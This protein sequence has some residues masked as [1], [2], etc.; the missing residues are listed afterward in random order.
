MNETLARMLA[1]RTM[2]LRLTCVGAALL[3]SVPL[4]ARELPPGPIG[5]VAA[6]EVAWD[7]GDAEALIGHLSPSS[8]ELSLPGAGGVFPRSQAEY[9]VRDWFEFSEARQFRV[10][11]FEWDRVRTG[12]ARLPVVLALWTHGGERGAVV[13]KLELQLAFESSVWYVTRIRSLGTWDWR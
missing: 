13:E 8:V 11:E 10:I 5:T 3:V 7:Q 9:L 1:A 4:A 6:I 12:D 2:R